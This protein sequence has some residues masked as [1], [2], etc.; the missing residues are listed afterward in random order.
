VDGLAYRDEVYARAREQGGGS[1][2]FLYLD[3]YRE[4]AG[5]SRRADHTIALIYGIGAVTRGASSYDPMSGETTMGSDTVARAIRSAVDDNSV[6]AIVFRVNSPGGSFVASDAIWRETLLARDAGKPVVITMG[7][8]AASGG[9]FVAMGA[10]GIVAQPGTITGSIGVLAGKM[11]TRDM[12]PKIGLSWDE[13]HSS[14][15]ATMWSGLRPY[16]PDEWS[17]LQAWLDRVYEDFTG[18][19]AEGRA[20]PLERVQEIAKGRVWT[21][22]EALEVGLIDAVG[23]FPT[24]IRL[25][26]EA[27][28][29]DPDALVRLKVFPARKTPLQHFLDETRESSDRRAAAEALRRSVRTLQPYVRQIRQIALGPTA[30]GPLSIPP[31]EE[32]D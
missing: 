17:R 6:D 31:M 24:A 30:Y 25:A 5:R 7:N 16:T 4:R 32:S 8:V 15:N 29:I 3:R 14:R 28:G 22:E 27:A 11:V 21:G 9:Y 2:R 23:G 13:V 1:A 12:W 18:K 20:L 10:D 26:K 19:V